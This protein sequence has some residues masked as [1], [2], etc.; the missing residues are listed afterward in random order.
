MSSSLSPVIANL[1]LQN[2]EKKNTLALNTL[3]FHILFYVHYVDDIAMA[4]PAKKNRNITSFQ[5]VSFS[6]TVH[7]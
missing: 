4:A 3:T 5:F 2:L 6:I 7:D 1:V